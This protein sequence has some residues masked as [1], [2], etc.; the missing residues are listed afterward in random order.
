MT[1]LRKVHANPNMDA[2]INPL[3]SKRKFKTRLISIVSKPISIVVDV[4]FVAVFVKKKLGPI[5]GM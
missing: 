1:Y 5:L 2:H 4:I 3:F